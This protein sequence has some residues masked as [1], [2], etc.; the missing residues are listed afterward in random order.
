MDYL[1][2]F[3]SN[4]VGVLVNF[5]IEIFVKFFKLDFEQIFLQL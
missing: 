3:V 5:R 2:E 4:F 1:Q